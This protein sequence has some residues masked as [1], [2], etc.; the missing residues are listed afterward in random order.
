M[1]SAASKE[2]NPVLECIYARRSIRRYKSDMVPESAIVIDHHM[3]DLIEELCKSLFVLF[4]VKL[5]GFARMPPHRFHKD[6]LVYDGSQDIQAN[7]QNVKLV[8]K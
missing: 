5:F 2:T 7:L 6:E 1:E 8:E 3:N 4:K